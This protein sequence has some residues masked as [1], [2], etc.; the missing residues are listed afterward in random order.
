MGTVLNMENGH[1][2]DARE[3]LKTKLGRLEMKTPISVASGTF[4]LDN[5]EFFDQACL[6]SFVTKTITKEPKKGNPPPRLFETE[7]GLIN[8]IGL[9]NPGLDEF[10]KS[11]LPCYQDSLSVPLV[12]SFSGSSIAEFALMLRELEKC[13][14]ISGYEINI[15]CPNV[16]NEGISF[17]V[18]A[19]V[20][21]KLCKELSPLTQK[22]L[23]VKLSPNV[24]FIDEIALAAEEGG[25]TS[26]ALINSLWGMA[27]DYKSGVSRIKKGVGGYTGMGVKPVAVALTYKVA[28]AVKIPIISMGGIYTWKD[29]LEFFWAGASAISLGTANFINPLAI[30][31]LVMGLGQFLL[32][33]NKSIKDYIGM[34]SF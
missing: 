34:V 28:Q 1:I 8:S 20:V 7:A 32:D 26:L 14:G 22:E 13:G 31:E 15:S 27:I 6:G 33:E 18:D 23:C 9:Q 19:E 17:G 29:A 10:I 11:S 16:E 30:P 25:A 12:V 5:L 2:R 24:T 4:D 21:Y 3:L